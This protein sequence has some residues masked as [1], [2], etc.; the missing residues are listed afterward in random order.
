[1]SRDNYA[2]LSH[3]IGDMENYETLCSFE[4]GI[5]HFERLFHIDPEAIAYDLHPNYLATQYAFERASREEIPV[6]GVQHHHA[7]IA[8]CLAE[9]GFTGEGQVIG[10]AFDGTGYGDDGAIW[11]GEVLIADYVSY[12]RL[13][14]LGYVP[15]AGGDKAIREPWRVALAWAKQAG[16]E[17][18]EFTGLNGNIDAET[19]EIVSRQI[20]LG[21]NAPL[22]S[23]MGRLFDAVAALCGVRA[24][25]NYEAQAAIELEGLADRQ[26]QGMYPFE[27]TKGVID[28][29]PLIRAVIEDVARDVDQS[30][31][32]AKFHN[33]IAATVVEICGQV[34][35]STGLH[36]VVLSGGVWQNMLLLHKVVPLLREKGYEVFLH[37]K[38]PANDGGIALGQ[39]AVA[40]HR[41]GLTG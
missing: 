5:S 12:E 34:R 20:E 27:I 36:Q 21:I 2:F 32:S 25:V 29:T 3:H 9:H 19:A 10:I 33:S 30:I 31:I 23:S 18:S 26:E 41:L 8:S 14:H 37:R 38:V 15:L 40:H 24:E 11:G 39:L 13:F 17:Q 28:P 7:H 1:M 16:L 35:E 6:V 22:T 4:D